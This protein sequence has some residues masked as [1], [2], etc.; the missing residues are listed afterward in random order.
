MCKEML[1]NAWAEFANSFKGD[2]RFILAA[3]RRTVDLK[4]WAVGIMQGGEGST[5]SKKET[6]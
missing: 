1:F 3:K 5:E 6:W 2:N 4:A